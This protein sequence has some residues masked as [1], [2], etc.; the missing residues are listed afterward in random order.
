MA[1][2]RL[3][4][5]AAPDD[6]EP[7][8]RTLA[9]IFDREL[10]PGQAVLLNRPEST[11]PP[12]GP[13]D[14]GARMADE[15]ELVR[16]ATNPT[17]DGW[18]ALE[19]AI[20]SGEISTGRAKPALGAVLRGL[21]TWGL[22]NLQTFIDREFD[23][24]EGGR[25]SVDVNEPGPFGETALMQAAANGK[26]SAVDTLLRA[27]ANPNTQNKDGETALMWAAAYNEV[28]VINLLL[29]NG[30]KPNTVDNRGFNALMVAA[31]AGNAEA[32]Q[33][34]KGKSNRTAKDANG[35]SAAE[36]AAVDVSP[37][38]VKG[39]QMSI[40][41]ML[42]EEPKAGFFQGI[43][44]AFTRRKAPKGGKKTQR[45]KKTKQKKRSTR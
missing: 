12:G 31:W 17:G 44:S 39:V 24:G 27:G 22:P 23:V 36:L 14:G 30:A 7:E 21:A 41:G 16:E 20:R 3:L 38:K 28:D 5:V 2:A 1:A 32:V 33:A 29:A 19:E 18:E 8:Q 43:K 4:R 10:P 26:S 35:F 13:M 25:L 11:R 9:E 34:L 42:A 6:M 15:A 37:S 45:R 40:R